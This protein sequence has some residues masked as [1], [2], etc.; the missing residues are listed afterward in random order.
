MLLKV[1]TVGLMALV[2]AEEYSADLYDTDYLLSCYDNATP[3]D[4]EGWKALTDNR[5]LRV[6]A[7]EAVR[8]CCDNSV[9]VGEEAGEDEREYSKADEL[10]VLFQSQELSVGRLCNQKNGQFD[11]PRYFSTH[12]VR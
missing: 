8:A 2:K 4:E 1:A 10:Y 3:N 12:Q 11:G 9:W 7:Y 5:D 6:A